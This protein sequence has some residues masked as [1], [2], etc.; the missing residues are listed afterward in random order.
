MDAVVLEAASAVYKNAPTG[1]KRRVKLSWWEFGLAAIALLG[2]SGVVIKITGYDLRTKKAKFRTLHPQIV[3][4]REEIVNIR[5]HGFDDT[6]SEDTQWP[7]RVIELSAH[8]RGIGVPVPGSVPMEELLLGDEHPDVLVW[9]T[10]LVN[11]AGFSATGD[12]VGAKR[13]M[14]TLI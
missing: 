9:E 2:T 5:V 10:Y 1:A 13:A 7:G 6:A 8:L 12:L 4:R 11:L 14:A 3:A